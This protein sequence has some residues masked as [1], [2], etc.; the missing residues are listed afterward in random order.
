MIFP[1]FPPTFASLMEHLLRTEAMKIAEAAALQSE[2]EPYQAVSV[3]QSDV[4]AAYFDSFA[5]AFDMLPDATFSKK[6]MEKAQPPHAWVAALDMMPARSVVPCCIGVAPSLVRDSKLVL[7]LSPAIFQRYDAWP[8]ATANSSSAP[9]ASNLD[10]TLQQIWQAG[11][12]RLQGRFEEAQAILEPM[13][14]SVSEEYKALVAN[15]LGALAWMQGDRGLARMHWQ[16]CAGCGTACDFNMGLVAAS[17]GKLSDARTHFENA[18][19]SWPETSAWHHLA[20]LY[21]DCMLMA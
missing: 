3:S 15:E 1:T 16:Q 2:V 6:S 19:N 21:R 10:D 20:M 9:T 8:V 14:Y 11:F 12:F 5:A 7:D 17:E 18:A 4:Q 13:Q